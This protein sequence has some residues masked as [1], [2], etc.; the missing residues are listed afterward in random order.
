VLRARP[1][2]A[3]G[4]RQREPLERAVRESRRTEPLERTLLDRAVRD[5]AV[6]DRARPGAAPGHRRVTKHHEVGRGGELRPSGLY[7]WILASPTSLLT[8]LATLAT[9]PST[10]L[11]TY[12][13]KCGSAV[14]MVADI[15]LEFG[16]TYLSKCGSAV[17][18]VADILLEFGFTYL[19]KCGCAVRMVGP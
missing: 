5:R 10:Y 13:S 2:T 11:H 16:F 6:R 4:C 7:C 14:P 8:H 18:M 9:Y 3:P 12:L 19:S 17:R 1:G 15:L